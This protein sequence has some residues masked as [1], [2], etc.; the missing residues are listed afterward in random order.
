M[1]KLPVILKGKK[2]SDTFL[3]YAEPCL[4]PFLNN[5]DNVN[6]EQLEVASRILG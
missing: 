2:G 3:D 4:L 5:K 6:I 1:S